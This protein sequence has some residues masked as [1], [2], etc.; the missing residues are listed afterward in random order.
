MQLEKL[1]KIA[2]AIESDWKKANYCSTRFH[3]VVWDHT[4]ENTFNSLSDV[5]SQLDF[6]DHQF[7]RHLQLSST[8]SD[9]FVQLFNNGRFTIEIL[10]WWGGQV[11][12][13][14]HD[15][16]AVQ[17]QLKGDALNVIYDFEDGDRQGAL[18]FGNLKIRNTNI[19]KEGSRS[20]VRAG[21]V[22]PH[23]VLHIGQPC[24]SLLVRTLPTKRYGAQSNYFPNLRAHYYVAT[25]MQRKKL[26]G[27]QL[28]AA[29]NLD[30]FTSQLSAYIAQQSLSENLFMLDKLSSI[31][32]QPNMKRILFS[33]V[34]EH[35]EIEELLPALIFNHRSVRLKK[36]AERSQLSY[37]QRVQL[38]TIAAS[39]NPEEYYKLIKNLESRHPD[40][41][42]LIELSSFS[43]LLSESDFKFIN[44]IFN[45]L[46]ETVAHERPA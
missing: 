15:F 2:N 20:I 10:N 35:Q 9:M 13:H 46:R 41:N 45:N 40:L 8:F 25:V 32:F 27:L 5:K 33:L 44:S 16:S 14:D 3:E 17:F 11:N 21:D 30:T 26:T 6:I 4:T 1:V 38:F 28:L 36:I 43:A 24:T 31:L 42:N 19:W 23:S 29:S 12:I 37:K 22:D 18:Q 34:S 39:P 7:V